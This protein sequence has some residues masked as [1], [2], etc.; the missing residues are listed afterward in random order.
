VRESLRESQQAVGRI[1]RMVRQLLDASR[2]A[3]NAERP[4]EPVH[5]GRA[6]HEAVRLAR[7]RTGDAS[8][9][10]D[11]PDDLWALGHDQLVV[12]VLVN[13]V[14]NGAQAIPAGRAGR[15]SVRGG[16]AGDLVRLLVEDDG[17]GMDPPTLRRVFEPF[18]TTKPFGAGTGLGL[19]VSRG[20]V[21]SMGG[22]LRLE[23]ALGVGTR[24][25]I[26]LTASAPPAEAPAVDALEAPKGRRRALLLVDD[27]P[28]VLAALSRLLAERYAVTVA[29]GADEGITFART[30]RFD[31]VL[32]DVMMPDGGAERLAAALEREAPAVAGRLVFLTAGATTA[33]ARDFLADERRPVLTKP[34]DLAELA[35]IVDGLTPHGPATPPPP[36]AR[37]STR[38]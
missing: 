36:P 25:T 31:A 26:E 34:L 7:A 11:V 18:F 28:A 30:G 6:T 4:C 29:A 3:S 5:L 2:L 38:P 32:C 23:S 35:R 22:D 12:Q 14:V 27:D 13:L 33:P 1:A 8:V 17:S 21:T 19:A 10:I 20:M 24:A 37:Q 16:R 15:I 9:E